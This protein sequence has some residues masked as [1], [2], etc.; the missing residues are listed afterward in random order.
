MNAVPRSAIAAQP[1]PSP[2]VAKFLKRAPRLFIGNEWVEAG[3]QGRVKVFDPATGQQITQVV[4]ANA[5]DVDRAVAAARAAFDSSA[6]AEMPPND[7][8][9]SG[10]GRE[11]G[12]VVLDLYT[13]VKSVCT[14]Y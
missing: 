12:R 13:E 7:R 1:A 4:D 5:S 9:Q 10:F 6:W 8:E 11:H 2:A 14:A 3:S